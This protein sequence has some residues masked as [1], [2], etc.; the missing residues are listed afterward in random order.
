MSAKA[1]AVAIDLY[2]KEV[3]A[4]TYVD[5]A[6]L[7]AVEVHPFMPTVNRSSNHRTKVPAVDMSFYA[8]VARSVNKKEM[9][10]VPAAE[11]SVTKEW[12]K[13]TK[14]KT[15]DE[16]RVREYSDVAAEARRTKT[17]THFGRL[18]EICVEKGSE[19]EQ[20][21]PNRKLRVGLCSREMM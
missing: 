12:D 15:W 4:G 3:E 21:D 20:D 18:L 16:S 9:R 14:I 8:L 17:K 11:A 2:K 13:L 7:A 19:L 1:K 10:S 6:A 5:Q